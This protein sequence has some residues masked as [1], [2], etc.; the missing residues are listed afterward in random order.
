[1]IVPHFGWIIFAFWI[2]R[3]FF[4]LL[5]DGIVLV[6]KSESVRHG[7]DLTSMPFMNIL[8]VVSFQKELWCN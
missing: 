3:I 4:E 6:P 5:L 1:M 7:H 2:K 8:M